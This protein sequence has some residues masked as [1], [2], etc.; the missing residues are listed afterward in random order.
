MSSPVV[1]NLKSSFNYA[2]EKSKGMCNMN[3]SR[4]LMLVISAILMILA[5]IMTVYSSIA[6]WQFNSYPHYLNRSGL[7]EYLTP[8]ALGVALGVSVLAVSAFGLLGIYRNSTCMVN[9]YAFILIV[10]LLVKIVAICLA[11]TF[12]PTSLWTNFA[13]PLGNLHKHEVQVAV[14]SLQSTVRC[15]GNTGY[16]DYRNIDLPSDMDTVF[17]V[18]SD[19]YGSNNDTNFTV[20]ASCCAPGPKLCSDIYAYHGCRYK[21]SRMLY[22]NMAIIGVLAIIMLCFHSFA[23]V[24]AL[25]NGCCIRKTKSEQTLAEWQITEQLIVAREERHK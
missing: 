10:L 20:P 2:F 11:V 3:C 25:V 6:Y 1:D 17:V 13:I 5:L 7:V 8:S 15:C 24:F 23:I 22:R 14:D 9:S 21:L 19:H 12:D 18:K 16:T 4:G